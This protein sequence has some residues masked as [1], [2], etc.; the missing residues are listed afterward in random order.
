VDRS[1]CG[2]GSSANLAVRHARGELR[3]GEVSISRSI[4][5][6]EF[7][8]EIIGETTVAGRSAVLPRITG[9]GWVYGTETLRV[10]GDDP[11]PTGFVLSDTWGSQAGR[12]DVG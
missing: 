4:I 10:D 9:E 5:G 8:A 6:G 7:R 12:L 11:F 1:P 3:V 2:T